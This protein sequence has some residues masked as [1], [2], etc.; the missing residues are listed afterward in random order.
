MTRGGDRDEARA[1][2]KLSMCRGVSHGTI[3]ALVAHFGSARA[4]AEAPRS[5]LKAVPGLSAPALG[6]LGRP[7][8][9]DDVEREWELATDCR[10]ELVPFTSERYPPLLR[11][12]E[13]D[14]PAL[15]RVRG[16]YARR[17]QLAVA[18]VGTRRCTPYGR[19]QAGRLAADLAGMG[20]TIVSGMA[21]GIDTAAHRGALLARGRTVAV[22]GCGI[23]TALLSPDAE[24]ALAVAEAGAL[25][26]ELPM[27][28]RPHPGHFPQR[29]RIISGLS[30]ATV[31]VEAA[32]RSGGLITARL[33]GEQGRTVCAVPG[34][35]DSPASR[36]CHA[37]I[38]D[39]AVLVRSAHDVVEALGPLSEP[40]ALAPDESSEERPLVDPRVLALNERERAILDLVGPSPQHIDEL[41]VAADLPPSIVS[42]T[43]MTLAIR[44]LIRQLPGQRYATST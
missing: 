10:T 42:S 20:F 25:V 7:P 41:V 33:A 15:L 2:L 37:L 30:L 23:Q 26:S 5:A 36:G 34:N 18:V 8:S 3:F 9:D 29:N 44:G 1:V 39:G 17:D 19:Q 13:R 22:L 35:V 4:A 11:S 38:R 12:L 14:A 31:V 27:E 40:I 6:G 43:L 21:A 24:L 16:D 32:D 28:A